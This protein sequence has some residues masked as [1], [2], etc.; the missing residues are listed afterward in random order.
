[1][2]DRTVY[3][4]CVEIVFHEHDASSFF[5]DEGFGCEASFFE[6]IGQ[7]F[8]TGTLH[9]VDKNLSRNRVEFCLI[10]IVYRYIACK[11]FCRV[12]GCRSAFSPIESSV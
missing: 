12:F 2:T 8:R 9:L 1:M 4:S 3:I 10:V 5:E 7:A 11:K 6:G